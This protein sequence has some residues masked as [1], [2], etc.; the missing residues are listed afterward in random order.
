MTV[1]QLDTRIVKACAFCGHSFFAKQ[2][3]RLTCS[4]KCRKRMSR[5]RKLLPAH[6]NRAIEL[7]AEIGSY[8]D[9]PATKHHACNALNEISKEVFLVL[10]KHNVKVI[11]NG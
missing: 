9:F 10:D 5:W 11:R 6:T 2:Q 7:L 4:D 3:N 1:R 8:L